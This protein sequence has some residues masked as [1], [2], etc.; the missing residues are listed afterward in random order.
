MTDLR[1]H[2]G[3]NPR[4]FGQMEQRRLAMAENRLRKFAI[5]PVP[6]QPNKYMPHIGAKQR[7]K[8]SLPAPVGT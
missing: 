7:S 6:K 8:S 5:V 1:N 4:Y 3:L 2:P